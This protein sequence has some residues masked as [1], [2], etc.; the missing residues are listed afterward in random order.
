MRV[1][2]VIIALLLIFSGA[3]AQE[4]KGKT[5]TQH[6]MLALSYLNEGDNEE[7]MESIT[8]A[9]AMNSGNE[10]FYTIRG[11]I[12]SAMDMSEKAIEDFTKSIN[13]SPATCDAYIFRA[14][15]YMKLKQYEKALP[16]LDGAI[17]TES[18]VEYEVYFLRSQVRLLLGDCEGAKSDAKIYWDNQ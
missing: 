9:I 10:F 16:D 14:K 18:Y 1:T 15:E 2:L 6:A 17:K 8:Q 13:L 7:A 4:N 3:E 5:A 12:Y 11:L